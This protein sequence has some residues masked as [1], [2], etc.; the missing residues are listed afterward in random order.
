MFGAHVPGRRVA[1]VGVNYA[2]M[3][4]VAGSVVLV[5]GFV[6]TLI[7]AAMLRATGCS[8]RNAMGL[9]AVASALAFLLFVAGAVISVARH[10]L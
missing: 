3:F 4:F 7:A 8:A 10:A 5:G 6:P 9:A 1:G 2:L